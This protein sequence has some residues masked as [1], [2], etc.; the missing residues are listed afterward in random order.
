MADVDNMVDKCFSWQHWQQREQLQGR[1]WMS[2]NGARG[3]RASLEMVP[4]AARAS[5][6]LVPLTAMA[7]EMVPGGDGSLAHA[8]MNDL[9]QSAD[10][11]AAVAMA[12][13]AAAPGEGGDE[14]IVV[15]DNL[16][17]T[18]LLGVEGVAALRGVSLTIRRGE[19]VM[20]FGTSGGGKSTLLKIIGTI[21]RPTKGTVSV[22]GTRVAPATP[23]DELAKLRLHKLGFV[24]QTFNLVAG[25]T[26][27]ENVEMPLTLQGSLSPA[28][29]NARC[30]SILRR[31]GMGDRMNHVPS[32]LSGGE[33]QRVTIARAMV[34]EPDLL[35]LD[36]PTGDLDSNNTETVMKILLEL[37][38]EHGVTVVMVTHD[39]HLRQFATRSIHL[40]DGKLHREDAP[41]P[42][43]R[44]RLLSDLFSVGLGR[45]GAESGLQEGAAREAEHA[46]EDEL[47]RRGLDPSA[48]CMTVI[49]APEAYATFSAHV[50][51]RHAV[52]TSSVAT[53]PWL[54]GE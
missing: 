49:R 48:C 5:L 11:A 32:Q 8:N 47:R 33:Q 18:Y 46:E 22:C 27:L 6:E 34:H 23:D 51:P 30:T 31:V 17:K 36:E 24:F 29:R 16:H 9:T 15:V 7:D 41:D 53:A 2:R 45:H 20:L 21:D 50:K 4:L 19:F 40:R 54:P 42:R 43:V 52:R 13:E 44:Q 10:A 3:A 1:P 35:L 37:N 38:R 28:E 12:A 14:R 25:M 39:E 26:A